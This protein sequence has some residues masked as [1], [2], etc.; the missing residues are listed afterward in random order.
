METVEGAYGFKNR[1]DIVVAFRFF[2]VDVL[3]SFDGNI[4]HKD[5]LSLAKPK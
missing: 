3:H 5:P 2:F 1:F 4:G